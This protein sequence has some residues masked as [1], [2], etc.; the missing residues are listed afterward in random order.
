MGI[1][2]QYA[3]VPQVNTKLTRSDRGDSFMEKV[4][5]GKGVATLFVASDST[6]ASNERWVRLLAN[7]ISAD[8]PAASVNYYDF[9]SVGQALNA[10]QNISA[11]TPNGTIGLKTTDNFARS[12]DLY[13]S[14]PDTGG[15]WNG[16]TGTVGNYTMSGGLC[17]AVSS[18]AGVI[19]TDSQV[20][21][22]RT[23]RLRSVTMSTNAGAGTV[24]AYAKMVD[25]IGTYVYGFISVN[26]DNSVSWGINQS[27]NGTVTALAVGSAN[28]IAAN[29]AAVAV[30]DVI[31]TIAGSTV[32]FAVNGHTINGT[33]TTDAVAA[34]QF[35]TY[36]GF[37]A[38]SQASVTI[39]RFEQEITGTPPPLSQITVYNGAVSGSILT[40]QAS[41]LTLMC[42]VTP[43]L[44]IISSC[45]NYGGDT[46]AV[47]G[48]KVDT[49]IAG[50]RTQWPT[51]GVMIMSQNPQKYPATGVQMHRLR[52]LAMRAYAIQAGIGYLPVFE[53]FSA[54]SDGGVSLVRSD[55]VHPTST[56]DVP[57]PNNGASLWTRT[58]YGTMRAILHPAPTSSPVLTGLPVVGPYSFPMGYLSGNYYFCNSPGANSTSTLGTG[59]MR[60]SP[61][62]VTSEVVVA[63]MFAEFTA[64]GDAASTLVLAVYGSD[65]QGR[66][67]GAPVIAPGSISTGTGNAGTVATGGTP[68]VYEIPVGVTLQPGL[69]WVAGIVQGVTTTQPTIRI[70]STSSL[71]LPTPYGTA[72]PGAAAVTGIYTL[73]G[74]TGSLPTLTGSTMSAQS[75]A[76]ARLGFKV[77]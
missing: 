42:P 1:D 38:N 22:D 6:G 33:L 77:T 28:P 64:A 75:A 74:V 72:L 45:H 20:A 59:T 49:F 7:K 10:V 63:K 62:V 55:G 51:A 12:G 66:P 27:V 35:A 15:V 21:G 73:A 44:T 52:N 8:Y 4:D 56:S 53:A 3:T 68:G 47:Y 23:V 26:A 34:M 60:L 17:S 13:G 57:D 54:R 25:L 67:N 32:T 29:T 30:G 46:P 2:A 41:R 37:L 50:L 36:D 48:P 16:T 31:L 39:D 58:V 5:S 9:D 69:Y 61:W 19:Q 65:A 14:T 18:S 76:A 43:D 40:Y 71:I 70:C 11:G 24:R